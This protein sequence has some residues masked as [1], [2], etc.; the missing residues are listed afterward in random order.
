MGSSSEAWQNEPY[1]DVYSQYPEHDRHYGL[2]VHIHKAD[3]GHFLY[4]TSQSL[5]TSP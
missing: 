3:I 4:L 5:N 2:H 1:S